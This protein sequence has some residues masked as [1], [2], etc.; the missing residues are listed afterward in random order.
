M[1]RF[2]PSIRFEK[3]TL[4]GTK[5]A[6]IPLAFFRRGRAGLLQAFGPLA[7]Q[8]LGGSVQRFAVLPG[9]LRIG[10]LEV[11][12]GLVDG[13]AAGGG[14]EDDGLALETIRFDERVDD[15][16]GRVP[17]DRES[18]ED[19]VIGVS[20]RQ[21]LDDGGTGVLVL[22]LHAAAG[23]SVPPVEVGCGVLHLGL[24][25]V[26][27]GAGHFGKVGRHGLGGAGGGKVGYQCFHVIFLLCAGGQYDC[28]RG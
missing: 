7:D 21:V 26:K 9:D 13:A 15:R 6:S 2:H 17:P 25:L 22:H 5:K 8:L 20:I 24:D 23:L 27:G 12:V 10:G 16:G 4:G 18:D 19:A 1:E 14:E 3:W 11:G 28:Q